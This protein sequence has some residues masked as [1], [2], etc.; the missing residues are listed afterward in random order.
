MAI[1]DGTHYL[2]AH[3]HVAPSECNQYNTWLPSMSNETHGKSVPQAPPETARL[4]IGSAGS[5]HCVN[6]TKTCRKQ[7]YLYEFVVILVN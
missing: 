3:P 5:A 6:L 1:D 4:F 7:G 2:K